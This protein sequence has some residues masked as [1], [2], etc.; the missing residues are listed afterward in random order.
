MKQQK[1]CTPFLLVGT[2][3]NA[4]YFEKLAVPKKRITI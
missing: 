4:N 1:S 2:E 3:N